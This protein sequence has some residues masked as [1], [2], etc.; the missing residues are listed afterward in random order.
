VPLL[1]VRQTFLNVLFLRGLGSDVVPETR[2]DSKPFLLKL[3]ATVDVPLDLTNVG[4]SLDVILGKESSGPPGK[5]FQDT[6]ALKLLDTV[7][8]GG[9]SARATINDNATEE[10]K[11]HFARFRSR[12]NQGELFTAMVGSVF[13]GFCSS[14]T[15]LMQRLNLPPTL[16]SCPDSVFMTQLDIENFS[17]YLEVAE[18]ADT[19]RW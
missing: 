13:L 17:A 3:D 16:V 7:R 12:L 8:T 19:S 6:N 15:P 10:E 2:S 9:P 1:F 5:F 14:E 4:Q 18:T 11:T